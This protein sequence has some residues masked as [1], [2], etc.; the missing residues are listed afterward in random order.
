ME[1]GLD[2]GPRFKEILESLLDRVMD[3]PALNRRAS[4]LAIVRQEWL[5]E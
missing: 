5:D 1:L 3:D 2:P 4:L